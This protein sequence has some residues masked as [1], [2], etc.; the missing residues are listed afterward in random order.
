MQAST[1][2]L[3]VGPINVHPVRART[4]LLRN[5]RRPACLPVSARAA[6]TLTPAT[7]VTP[8]SPTSSGNP[9]LGVLNNALLQQAE[10]RRRSVDVWYIQIYIDARA[11]EHFLNNPH[12]AVRCSDKASKKS[13]ARQMQG[14]LSCTG[15]LTS[16]STGLKART[17]LAPTP[18]AVG[19]STS[20]HAVHAIPGH[21]LPFAIDMSTASMSAA[22]D[23]GVH[24]CLDSLKH[25]TPPGPGLASTVAMLFWHLLRHLP[26][27]KAPESGYT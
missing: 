5:R 11:R 14:T 3:R 9:M 22:C 13:Q 4:S 6:T 18:T 25:H 24:S 10:V 27:C 26:Q 19:L 21:S 2:L 15:V 20:R 12:F 17:W 1:M 8:D 7:V 16:G 23:Q